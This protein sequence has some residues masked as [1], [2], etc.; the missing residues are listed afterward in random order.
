MLSWVLFE[1]LVFSDAFRFFFALRF[2]VS[3]YHNIRILQSIFHG[4]SKGTRMRPFVTN[5]HRLNKQLS[6]YTLLTALLIRVAIPLTPV[7]RCD[8]KD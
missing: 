7:H 1:A 5:S 8:D 2:P 4:N 6:Y 3:E